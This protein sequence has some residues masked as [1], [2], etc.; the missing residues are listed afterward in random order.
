MTEA[1]IAVW[2]TRA[3]VFPTIEAVKAY[4]AAKAYQGTGIAI[5]PDGNK[6]TKE[7]TLFYIRRMGEN[8]PEI[9]RV[10][11]QRKAFMG[12]FDSAGEKVFP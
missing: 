2:V 5:S 4:Y 11:V 9:A 1:G 8:Q 12:E 10:A 3:G 7:Y 6:P